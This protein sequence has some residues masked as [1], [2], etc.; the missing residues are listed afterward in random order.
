MGSLPKVALGFISLLSA[1]KAL[2]GC[3]HG[4]SRQKSSSCQWQII[5]CWAC[6][7]TEYKSYGFLVTSTN[8]TEISKESLKG[9]AKGDC[10]VRTPAESPERVDTWWGY[11]SGTTAE[12]PKKCRKQH[13][14]QQPW[15]AAEGLL[16][17]V[18]CLAVTVLKFLIILNKGPHIFIWHRSLILCSLLGFPHTWPC[19]LLWHSVLSHIYQSEQLLFSTNPR[20]SLSGCFQPMEGITCNCMTGEMWSKL[21]CIAV[22][23]YP[24]EI[25]WSVQKS[26]PRPWM[27]T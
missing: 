7:Y 18:R 19:W 9:Q 11:G 27:E 20:G 3:S 17:L 8:S 21:K 10:R 23:T 26:S 25:Q 13:W 22:P 14:A 12:T 1:G 6:R 16:G 24:F 2:K 15:K 4:S 5:L